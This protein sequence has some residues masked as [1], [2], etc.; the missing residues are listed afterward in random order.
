M[1]F[2]HPS[3]GGVGFLVSFVR[4]FVGGEAFRGSVTN[5]LMFLS[6]SCNFGQSLAS[7]SGAGLSFD[8]VSF[9]GNNLER[10]SLLCLN[11]FIS[12]TIA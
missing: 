3:S 12:R 11:S 8:I 1:P 9:S 5:S 2:A 6:R 4:A 10:F 7:I